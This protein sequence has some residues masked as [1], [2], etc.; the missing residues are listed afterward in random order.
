M[1]QSIGSQRVGCDLMT[2]QHQQKPNLI[3]LPITIDEFKEALTALACFNLLLGK[4]HEHISISVH[5]LSHNLVQLLVSVLV[6][7]RH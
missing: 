7:G 2:E 1:L 5:S 6:F 3:F 4:S